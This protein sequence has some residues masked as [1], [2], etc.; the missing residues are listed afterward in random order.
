MPR[1]QPDSTR[2]SVFLCGLRGEA[3][4]VFMFPLR[5]ARGWQ[6]AGREDKGLG[7]GGVE[8]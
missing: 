5:A 4:S 1:Y 8:C 2:N 6:D 7:M 3:S